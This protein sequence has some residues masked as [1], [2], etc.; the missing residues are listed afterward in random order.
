[1]EKY[2]DDMLYNLL[3]YIDIQISNSTRLCGVSNDP[4]FY[5]GK[6]DALQDIR[7]EIVKIID[8]NK[9]CI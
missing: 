2:D 5:Y 6:I 4:S 9:N 8:D 1:M 7:R 3:N